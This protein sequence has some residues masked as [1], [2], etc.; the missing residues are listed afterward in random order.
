MGI[1]P[2]GLQP[3]ADSPI[4]ELIQA[5]VVQDLKHAAPAAPRRLIVVSDMMQHSKEY[6][7]YRGTDGEVFFHGPLFDKVATDLTGIDVRV[8]YI[9]RVSGA[10]RQPAGHEQFWANYF[11]RLGARTFVIAP[12]EGAAWKNR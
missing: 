9:R 3:Q 1:G 12:V 11:N 10:S 7:Q 2:R 5:T 6:S 8:L 4:M